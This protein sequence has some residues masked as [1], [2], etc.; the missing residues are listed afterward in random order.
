MGLVS[1]EV[2]VSLADDQQG[3]LGFTVGFYCVAR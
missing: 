1:S 2:E 3:L